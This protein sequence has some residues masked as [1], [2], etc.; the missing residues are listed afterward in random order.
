MHLLTSTYL[1]L[2]DRSD[3]WNH[4]RSTFVQSQ[5]CSDFC[6]HCRSTFLHLHECLDLCNHCRSIFFTTASRSVFS[7]MNVPIYMTVAGRLFFT[8]MNTPIFVTS[9]DWEMFVLSHVGLFSPVW[10][11]RFMEP[12]HFFTYMSVQIYVTIPGRVSPPT[13]MFWVTQPM[14]STFLHLRDCSNLCNQS[15]SRD[16]CTFSH[17]PVFT[18]MIVQIYETIAVRLVQSQGCSDFCNQF[19]LTFLHLYKCSFLFVCY[20]YRPVFFTRMTV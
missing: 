7:H 2:Y 5:G 11:F 13:W 10:A 3:F 20:H 15:R 14:Q 1:H 6:N 18:C 19:R 4:C 17:R 9:P 8:Y 16:V 12:L